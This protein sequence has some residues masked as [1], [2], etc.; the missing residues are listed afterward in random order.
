MAQC[1]N[2][3]HGDQEKEMLL[4]EQITEKSSQSP[5]QTFTPGLALPDGREHP[6]TGTA[7]TPSNKGVTSTGQALQS[8]VSS[9]NQVPTLQ[10]LTLHWDNNS[11]K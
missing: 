4:P 7:H 5:E 8:A 10:E 11:N 3:I 2:Q 9:S 6:H 1:L